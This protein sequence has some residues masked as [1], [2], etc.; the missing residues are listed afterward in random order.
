MSAGIES[1]LMYT[2]CII[3]DRQK[4]LG[5]KAMLAFS[6]E[7]K[8]WEETLPDLVLGAKSLL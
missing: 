8:D 2:Q 1:P 3:C 6:K 4:M 5:E 7:G